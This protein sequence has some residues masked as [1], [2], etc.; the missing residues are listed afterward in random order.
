MDLLVARLTA[1]RL[2]TS[3]HPE[4]FSTRHCLFEIVG[5]IFTGFR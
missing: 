5:R 2:A 1:M 3:D 4:V